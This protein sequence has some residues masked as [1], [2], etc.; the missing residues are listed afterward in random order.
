MNTTT[1][2]E[3]QVDTEID[4]LQGEIAR[5]S[6]H[7]DANLAV[8]KRFY[9]ADEFTVRTFPRLGEQADAAH[10]ELIALHA[11]RRELVAALETEEAK[12]TGWS[13]YY[14]VNN[15]NGHLHLDIDL[16]NCSSCFPTTQYKWITQASGLDEAE[17]VELAGEVCCTVCFP[18]APVEKKADRIFRSDDE[19]AKETRDAERAAKR[20]KKLE[21]A[22]RTDGE[23]LRITDFDGRTD[24][25]LKTITA[26][27]NYYAGELAWAKSV[28]LHH[29][30]GGRNESLINEYLSH[31]EQALQGLTERFGTDVETARTRLAPKLARKFKAEGLV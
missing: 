20:A 11:Q 25:L 29:N 1:R 3:V 23:E 13:R 16:N 17:L 30:D 10:Y 7:I 28:E 19:I 24:E 27:E 15:S 14:R 31:A 21:K 26:T 4:R 18:S 8:I 22:I 6:S 5:V 12:Y 2:Y 9:D